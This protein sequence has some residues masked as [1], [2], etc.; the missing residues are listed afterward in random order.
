LESKRN[1]RTSSVISSSKIPDLPRQRWLR[2]PDLSSR[3]GKAQIFGDGD[4]VTEVTK[5]HP[6]ASQR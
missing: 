4:E 1:R 3:F 2:E 6:G 5:F